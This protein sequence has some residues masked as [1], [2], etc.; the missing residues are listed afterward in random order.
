MPK[1]KTPP[2]DKLP[3][4]W[5]IV[6]IETTGLHGSRDRIIE[7]AILRIEKNKLVDTYTTLVNPQTYVSPFIER[8]TGIS[9]EELYEAPV[10]DDIKKNV[11]DLLDGAVFVAHNARF[12]YGFI[13]SEFKRTGHS[14]TAKTLCTVKLSRRLFPQ[15]RRHGLDALIDRYGLGFKSR[16]RAY[17]DAHAVW[18]FLNIVRRTVPKKTFESTVRILLS[19]SYA[20]SESIRKQIQELPE[21]SGIYI[22]YDGENIPLYI[23]KSTNIKE[24]VISHFSQDYDSPRELELMKR[25]IRI[26]SHKTA[27][28][29]GALIKESQLVKEINPL[30]NKKLR[31]KKQFVAVVK[32][33]DAEGFNTLKMLTVDSIDELIWEDILGT[34][35]SKRSAKEAIIEI[36]KTNSLCGKIMGMESTRGSCFGYK[37]DRCRGAC[38]GKENKRIYNGRFIIAFAKHRQFH[39]WP[40]EGAVEIIEKNEEEN[41]FETFVFDKWRLVGGIRQNEELQYEGS[42][43]SD[44]YRIISHHLKYK[45]PALKILHKRMRQRG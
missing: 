35:K 36:T 13:R 33:V 6:D 39:S 21:S 14:F 41:L 9:K 32:D 44:I 45:K 18:Q 11:L 3:Q 34:F 27:G 17:D 2:Q 29:L 28:E 37:L 31:P 1:K 40:Y 38:C 16:H 42:F 30:L 19:A 20:G 43:D 5:A 7:L 26:E 8:F 25:T 22:F 4:S 12:D 24:R 10:F 23:G 15:H